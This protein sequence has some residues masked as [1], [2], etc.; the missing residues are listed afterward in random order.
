MTA[1]GHVHRTGLQKV[2]N[3]SMQR[4]GIHSRDGSCIHL[5]VLALLLPSVLKYE[6]VCTCSI[7]LL[8]HPFDH[9]AIAQHITIV[10][11]RR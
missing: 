5:R 7:T 6:T 9:T 3:R 1:Q 11:R 4:T 8:L 2:H 10:H